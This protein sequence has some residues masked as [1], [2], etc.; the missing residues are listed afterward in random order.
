MRSSIVYSAALVA[1]I[2]SAAPTAKR[3]FSP[4]NVYFPLANGFPN[5]DGGAVLEIQKQAHGILPNGPPPH[6]ISPEGATNLKLLALNELFEV[7]FFTELVYN[8]TN[9]VQGYDLGYGHEY[10]LDSLNAIIAQEQL[11]LLNVNGALTHFQ[12]EPIQPCKYSFPVV[13]F[14]SAIGLA[15]LFTDVVL[16]TLQDVNQIFAEGQD[17]GLV[18]AVSSVLGNEAEQEGFFRLVQKKRP[19]AQP[20]LTTA[21]RDFAFTAIQ[22]FIIPGSC[23]NINTIPLKTFKGLTVETTGIQAQSQH[24]KFSFA[25]ADLGLFQV[26]QLR[27]VFLNG[28]TVPIV[29]HLENVHTE[30]DRIYFQGQFPFD[31][32]VMDGLTIAAVTIG[33]DSFDDAD[34]VAKATIF[35]P[36]L[37]E[38]E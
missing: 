33:S 37:I 6:T 10:V 5:P 30:G 15:A 22:G 7:A 35:G 3:D 29:K 27:L 11:H 36:G 21:T 2:A 19:S 32:F 38:V 26:D 24:I 34:A 14:Q 9:K 8:V 4:D 18:R 31:E 17:A 13:D 23:P 16:G 20:F 12:L 25:Q 1:S 28:Q